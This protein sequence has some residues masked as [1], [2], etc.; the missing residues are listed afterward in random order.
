ML[1]SCDDGTGV[2]KRFLHWQKEYLEYF[3]LEMLLETDK[4]GDQTNPSVYTEKIL[5]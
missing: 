2:S 1:V 5:I 3:G 4:L